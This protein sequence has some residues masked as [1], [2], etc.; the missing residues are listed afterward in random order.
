[1]TKQ[2]AVLGLGSFGYSMAI[3][4]EELGCEVVAV[5]SSE[6]KVQQIADE[7]SYAVCADIQDKDFIKALGARNLDGV[8]VAISEN[9]E[10]SI[11]ATL[12]AKELGAPYVLAKAQSDIHADIL[13]KLG[14]DKVVFPEQEMGRRVAKTLATKNFTDW[15]S[16]SKDFSMVE[17][18]LPEAWV[19]KC[20]LE[21]NVREK[22]GINVVGIIRNQQVTVY[23][24]PQ[25]CLEAGDMM[26]LI[27]EN[28]VL[29]DIS[30]GN[31][32]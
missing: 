23:I 7:V 32:V 21:L 15:I 9:L 13:K 22:F 14:A 31:L 30:K 3:T 16:L 18:P 27:G 11:L 17:A 5:D 8:V 6:D 1:M 2:F 26:I 29:N 28:K 19:G 24:Q 12:L 20:L 10:V 25:E 4:L